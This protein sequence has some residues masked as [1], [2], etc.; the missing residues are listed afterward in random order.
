MYSS[1]ICIKFKR[2]IIN[3]YGFW[4]IKGLA[5]L[6]LL[7]WYCLKICQ[8]LICTACWFICTFHFCWIAWAWIFLYMG[9]NHGNLFHKLSQLWFSS[10]RTHRSI[11]DLGENNAAHLEFDWSWTLAT[12]NWSFFLCRLLKQVVFVVFLL[13]ICFNALY[14]SKDLTQEGNSTDLVYLAPH[15]SKFGSWPKSDNLFTFLSI[16]SMYIL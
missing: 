15:L 4:I 14:K 9:K 3:M 11:F 8:R 12:L 13:L 2:S 16:H 6:F 1:S 7:F 10:N 5:C